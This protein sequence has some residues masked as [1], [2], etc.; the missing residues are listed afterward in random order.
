MRRSQPCRALS[1]AAI[2]STF[3]FGAGSPAINAAESATPSIP[4]LAQPAESKIGFAK[5]FDAVVDAI[6][7]NFVDEELLKRM[8]W[9]ARAASLRPSVLLAPSVDDAV[10]QINSLIVELK[11]SHTVLFTPDDYFYYL[12]LDILS[13]NA[14]TRDLI[15]RRF[16]SAG[17]YFPGIG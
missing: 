15:T 11:T 1:Y 5:L 2:L 4:V 3:Y 13:T 9:R 17:P 6:D 10:R 14:D 7:R 12:L 8:D 16:W